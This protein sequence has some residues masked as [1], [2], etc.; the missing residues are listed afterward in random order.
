ME[1]SRINIKK[2]V[3]EN[4]HCDIFLNQVF[5]EEVSLIKTMEKNRSLQ[6]QSIVI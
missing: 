5:M 1:S 2:I 3:I 6:T 4:K